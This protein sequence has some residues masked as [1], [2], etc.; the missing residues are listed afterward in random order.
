M[1]LQATGE[2]MTSPGAPDEGIE[3]MVLDLAHD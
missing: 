3:V 2:T 1:G